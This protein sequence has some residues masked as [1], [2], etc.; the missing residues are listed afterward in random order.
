MLLLLELGRTTRRGYRG[1]RVLP[2][3]TPQ[4]EQGWEL[5]VS[6]SEALATLANGSS[7]AKSY[8][9]RRH[10]RKSKLQELP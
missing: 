4:S 8:A 2:K 10:K 3:A 9:S 6:S 1:D 5:G 7:P